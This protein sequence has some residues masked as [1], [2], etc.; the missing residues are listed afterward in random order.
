MAK[1][2]GSAVVAAMVVCL[3]VLR[4]ET[5]RAA[6]HTVGG[7]R[8]WTFNTVDWPKGQTFKTGDTLV[9]NYNPTYHNVVAV[10]YAGYNNCKTPKGAKIY[11]SGKDQI[12]LVKG[13]NFFICNFPGHCESGMKIAINAV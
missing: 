7:T 10:D 2:R 6:P 13:K 4:F 9:F 1:G 8:G 5:A 11:K 12:K 3:L